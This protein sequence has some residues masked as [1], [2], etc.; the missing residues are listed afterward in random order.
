MVEK[1][2][3][4][5]QFRLFLTG[6]W[7][8]AVLSVVRWW[9]FTFRTPGLLLWTL[10]CV[11]LFTATA[12]LLFRNNLF[13]HKQSVRSPLI[14]WSIVIAIVFV[15]YTLVPIIMI[16]GQVVRTISAVAIVDL[17]LPVWIAARAVLLIWERRIGS[18]ILIGAIPVAL[19]AAYALMIPM[20]GHSYD[21]ELPAPDAGHLALSKRLRSHVYALAGDIG[22]RHYERPD[23]LRAAEHYVASQL[24]GAGYVV[25][26][27]R[28]H[29]DNQEYSNFEVAIP[30]N[31][32][33]DEIVV[34]GG[35]YDSVK[36]APGA[37]DNASAV[38]ALIELA[39]MLRSDR[40]A[41]TIRFVAFTNEEPPHFQ[42]PGMGSRV[43]ARAAARSG[44]DIVAML[45]LETIGYFTD[46]PRSQRY[47]WPFSLFYPDRGNFIAFVGDLGS[48]QLVRQSVRAFRASTQF[49]A[50]GVAA[51]AFIPG[52][53]WSDHASF[54]LYGYR[55]L[56]ITDTAPF[57][58]DGYHTIG[59]TPDKLDYIRMGRVVQGIAAV[60]RA[61]AMSAAA[62]TVTAPS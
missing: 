60:I 16:Q 4:R 29:A 52:V 31:M 54:W 48:R 6:I 13:Q 30:G 8:V 19:L 49:P 47:P 53:N 55:A 41:R 36:G 61:Q 12:A 51:A 9:V 24:A 27:Q 25:K 35:H 3:H 42:T 56:M 38:A 14:G 34:V 2:P 44:A 10:A 57:R 50:H 43:Y 15:A 21:G 1:L 18:R 28:Y 23:A 37:D 59:D 5:L 11:T 33:A 40:P 17:V 20:P 26:A 45:S 22:E 62:T 58:F 46:E 32:R 7:I 39:R